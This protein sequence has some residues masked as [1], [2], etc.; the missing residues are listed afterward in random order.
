MGLGKTIQSLVYIQ[1]QIDIN[2]E[3]KFLVVCPSSLVY[4]W[5]DEVETFAPKLTS[6]IIIG[7][8][9]ERKNI[10]QSDKDTDIWITSYPLIRRDID[11][12]KEVFSTQFS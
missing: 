7:T 8:P 10:I 6:K 5:Q 9:E 4:N 1:S 12:Y 2:K 11:L 3:E